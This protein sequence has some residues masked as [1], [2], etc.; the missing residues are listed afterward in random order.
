MQLWG[1]LLTKPCETMGFLSFAPC[2]YHLKYNDI[3]RNRR[4]FIVVIE[5]LRNVQNTDHNSVILH[6]SVWSYQTTRKPNM[7]NQYVAWNVGKY[8]MWRLFFEPTSFSTSPSLSTWPHFYW[9]DQLRMYGGIDGRNF[10]QPII[11]EKIFR[12]ELASDI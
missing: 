2:E 3:K 8:A 11:I 4:L 5:I 7:V 12:L 9:I 10:Y 1:K 6:K